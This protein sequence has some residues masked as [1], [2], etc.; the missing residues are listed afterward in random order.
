[1]K[2]ESDHFKTL[3]ELI[4]SIKVWVREEDIYY[5]RWFGLNELNILVN[6]IERLN[7]IINELKENNER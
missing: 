7:N 2:I 6:E 4:K 3:E 1:M 5:D